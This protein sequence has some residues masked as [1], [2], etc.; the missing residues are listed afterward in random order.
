MHQR[1]SS[2]GNGNKEVGLRWVEPAPDVPIAQHADRR[3]TALLLVHSQCLCDRLQSFV[4]GV[5]SASL[6]VKRDRDQIGFDF[7][8]KLKNGKYIPVSFRFFRENI[9]LIETETKCVN[10][11]CLN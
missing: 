2:Q 1:K 6:R 10:R 7:P 5:R 8:D 3:I 11:R 4:M 9:P